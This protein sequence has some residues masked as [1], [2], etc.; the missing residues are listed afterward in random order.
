ML[1]VIGN[2]NYFNN[3]DKIWTYTLT[4]LTEPIYYINKFIYINR[5]SF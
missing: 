5:I 2:F 3:F 4:W 1:D